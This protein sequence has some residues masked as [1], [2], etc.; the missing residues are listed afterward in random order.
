MRHIVF[1]VPLWRYLTRAAFRLETLIA[2]P[3]RQAAHPRQ[4]AT[5]TSFSSSHCI[6]TE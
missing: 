5:A 4:F 6:G 3:N 1:I 2:R